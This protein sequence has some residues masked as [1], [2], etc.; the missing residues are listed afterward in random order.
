MV[1]TTDSSTKTTTEKQPL[2]PAYTVTNINNKIRTLDGKKVTYSSWVKLFKLHVRAYKVHQHIDGS[3]P[4]AETD[5]T[6]PAW[7]EL[8][9]LILQWIYSTL[10]D[11]LLS[12][13]L[14]TDFT[15]RDAWLKIQ[16]I[17]IN[18]KHA[19]AATLENKFTNTTLSSCASFD[20][21]CLTLKS[22]AEQLADVD[23]PVT[24]SRLVIQ[25]VRGLP[26]EFDTIGAII[27]QS[28]PSWDDARGMIEEEQQRQSART[29]ASRD[30]VLLSSSQSSASDSV[31]SPYPNGYRGKHYDPAKAARGRGPT[32][33]GGRYMGRG[34]RSQNFAQ[35]TVSRGSNSWGQA[36]YYQPH[37][38]SSQQPHTQAPWTPPPTPYPS[39][40]AHFN[41]HHQAHVAQQ[42]PNQPNVNPHQ[43][44][45][46]QQTQSTPPPGFEPTNGNALCPSDIGMALSTLSLN[47]SDPQWYM[48]TGASSH[49]TS[50]QG[51]QGWTPP[52]PSQ[53]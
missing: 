9:A 16:D 5:P 45:I 50:D 29:T 31:R 23:Q 14:N 41:Q 1:E 43:T 28:K 42:D 34:D 27:H 46:A 32:G 47:Y 11:D 40:P 44:Y 30:A 51:P 35:N 20:D 18:N 52:F 49:I 15:A 4:P 2:H 17:F 25:M 39:Q 12:R 7:S 22:L 21:Y 13:V 24:D 36:Q 10:S 38:G 33:R 3:D 8:D 6:Y 26:I 48:D 37:V 53:Q 19:R